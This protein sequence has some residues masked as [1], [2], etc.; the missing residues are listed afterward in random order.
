MIHTRI[1][2]KHF[3]KQLT[4]LAPL[5]ILVKVL[6]P[7]NTGRIGHDVGDVCLFMRLVE[8]VCARSAGK[9]GHVVSAVGLAISGS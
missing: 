9:D 4:C 2:A 5:I 6:V 7:A 8:E 3:L 1:V